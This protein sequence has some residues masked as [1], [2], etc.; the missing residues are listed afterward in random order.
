M[1]GK[2]YGYSAF[3]PSDSKR[4]V[5]FGTYRFSEAGDPLETVFCC[6]LTN[7]N[8]S[9]PGRII[10][11]HTTMSL[12]DYMNFPNSTSGAFLD[13]DLEKLQ[14]VDNLSLFRFISSP[15]TAMVAYVRIANWDKV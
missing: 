3:D 14:S 8:S 10:I 12:G 13:Y 2:K 15:T 1:F 4:V 9:A 5:R 6:Q 7:T 11:G